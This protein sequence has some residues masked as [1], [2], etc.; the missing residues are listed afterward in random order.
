MELADYFQRDDGSLPE[1]EVHFKSGTGVLAGLKHLFAHGARDV[2]VGGASLWVK[3]PGV[4]RSFQGPGDAELV[5]ARIADPFH[6]VLADITYAGS[7]L[8]DLG[9]F[10]FD[11]RLVVD[12][13]MGYDWG[14]REIDAL[15][16]L[17]QGLEKL[18][19]C[20]SATTWWGREIAP[21]M[22]CRLAE[23]GKS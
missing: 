19:G 3:G 13:R 17:L 18:G 11:D 1:I 9:V 15:L 7:A 8:P 21:L 5:T 23:L 10:V 22:A 6:M 12:Y 2:S 20:F 16:L 14:V 4:S